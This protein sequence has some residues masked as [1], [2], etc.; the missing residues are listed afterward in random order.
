VGGRLAVGRL[1][2]SYF[3]VSE[4]HWR[5]PSG[6]ASPRYYVA[7]KRETGAG[8]RVTGRP[9]FE[10]RLIVSQRWLGVSN[11]AGAQ[12]ADASGYA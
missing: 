4:R 12:L 11:V 5:R 10:V 1:A 6:I 2:A 7:M 9:L 3:Y 8:K